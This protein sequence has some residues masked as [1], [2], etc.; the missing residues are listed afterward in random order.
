MNDQAEKLRIMARNLKKE[1]EKDMMK[2]ITKTRVIVVTSGKGGVGKTNISLNLSLVLSE[3][4][5]KVI[6]MDADMGMANV[7]IILGIVPNYNIYHLISKKKSITDILVEGPNNIKIIPGASGIKEL[8]NLKEDELKYVINEIAKLDGEAD[9]LIVDT[10]AGIGSNVLGFMA[11]ADDVI[12]VAVP[13][14]T[15]IAD[16]YGAIKSASFIKPKSNFHLIINRVKNVNEGKS[17]AYRLQSVCQKF[18]GIE[19]DYLG[20]VSEDNNVEKSVR[21]QTALLVSQPNSKAS[22]DIRQVARNLFKQ[23]YVPANSIGIRGFFKKMASLN[24]K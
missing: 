10:G 15:S 20:S 18:I 21:E 3:M 24:W 19:L 2:S 22:N 1:I 11:S 6:L 14:P 7:D 23:D 8:A 5:K 9:I 4:G 17:V 16:A 12:I 13:E